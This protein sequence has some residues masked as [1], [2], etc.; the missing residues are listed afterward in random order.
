MEGN[1][2]SQGGGSSPST[3]VAGDSA[4]DTG[5]EPTTPLPHYPLRSPRHPHH[6]NLVSETTPEA[7]PSMA[8]LDIDPVAM[9]A[10]L[11]RILA[12]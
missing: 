10:K 4:M 3:V 12:D 9:D 8:G 11:D 2:T 7:S 6:I 1:R 5:D